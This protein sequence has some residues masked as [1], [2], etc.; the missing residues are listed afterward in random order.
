MHRLVWA[1]AGRTYHIVGNLMS[2]L[3]LLSNQ[4][5]QTLMR[6]CGISSGSPMFAKVPI[7]G[8]PVQR[9]AV[10][11]AQYVVEWSTLERGV[12]GLS[13]TLLC[14]WA[15]K[16]LYLLVSNQE[17]VMTWLRN[18]WLGW[19]TSTQTKLVSWR[20]STSSNTRRLYTVTSQMDCGT[21]TTVQYACG[22]L[23]H[24]PGLHWSFDI[25]I[26]LFQFCDKILLTLKSNV[27]L[28]VPIYKSYK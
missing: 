20:F 23:F 8:F 28:S 13:L 1:Y 6:F 4:K 21:L 14:P 9:R 25:N 2:R 11:I 3:K 12:A 22:Y 16:T 27:L 24:M 10:H 17:Y 7:Y 15:I 5:V 19:K 18:C 26:Y